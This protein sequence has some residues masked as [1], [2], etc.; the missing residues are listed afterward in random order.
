MAKSN[1]PSKHQRLLPMYLLALFL[2]ASIIFIFIVPM[3]MVHK[4][5]VDSKKPKEQRELIYR[6]HQ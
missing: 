5:Q 4:I 6:P 3:Y 2:I 1:R